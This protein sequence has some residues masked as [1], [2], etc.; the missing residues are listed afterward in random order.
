MLHTDNICSGP[1]QS[2]FHQGHTISAVLAVSAVRRLR[3]QLPSVHFLFPQRTVPETSF[4]LRPVVATCN[5]DSLVLT[6]NNRYDSALAS[7][8]MNHCLRSAYS[9][10][11]D[12]GLPVTTLGPS[13]TCLRQAHTGLSQH[14]TRLTEAW[15]FRG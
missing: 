1:K 8:H 14:S 5:M 4:L 6:R 7:S 2:Q 9:C 13:N 10:T 11:S 12:Q 3:Q 15:P